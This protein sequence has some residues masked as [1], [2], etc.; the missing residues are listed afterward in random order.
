MNEPTIYEMEERSEAFSEL[1]PQINAARI[2]LIDYNIWLMQHPG[3]S[4][5][6][7]MQERCEQEFTFLS[8]CGVPV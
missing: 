3:Q 2:Y 7:A 8:Y 1:E 5:T 4:P 6:Q